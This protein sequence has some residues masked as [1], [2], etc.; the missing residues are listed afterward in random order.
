VKMNVWQRW[1]PALFSFF[2]LARA[3]PKE[4]AQKEEHKKHKRLEQKRCKFA[5]FPS[6]IGSSVPEPK[7]ARQGDTE[8]SSVRCTV[9]WVK[10][11]R[12]IIITSHSLF[13]MGDRG[14]ETKGIDIGRET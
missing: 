9:H 14:G 6:H 5:L 2:A 7:A 4:T 1:A 13:I 10:Y 11:V 3:K 12:G 8:G